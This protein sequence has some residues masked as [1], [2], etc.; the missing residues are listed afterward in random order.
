MGRAFLVL[1][2]LGAACRGKMGPEGQAGQP[3][4]P[5]DDGAP[6]DSGDAGPAGPPGHNGADAGAGPNGNL[7]VTWECEWCV[8]SDKPSCTLDGSALQVCVDDGGGCGHWERVE[9]C[10]FGCGYNPG[11]QFD[12]LGNPQADRNECRSEAS[13]ASCWNDVVCPPGTECRDDLG[14]CDEALTWVAA[15]ATLTTAFDGK[16]H[17]FDS[18][19]ELANV[20]CS[21]STASYWDQS[22]TRNCS[23]S[24]EFVR[25]SASDQGE[26]YE[27]HPV[28]AGGF[29][30]DEL[31]ETGSQEVRCSGDALSANKFSSRLS[32]CFLTVAAM[33]LT[34]GGFV[35]GNFVR[36]D[37]VTG[38]GDQTDQSSFSLAG[39]FRVQVP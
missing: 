37:A 21:G 15:S 38:P 20:D 23:L 28:S 26:A 11:D 7:N 30:V 16:V 3:G 12:D 34:P 31:T 4:L 39:T 24:L 14:T 5:G 27:G 8:A 33:D 10:E 2:V 29:E 6:G 36:T 35:V 17:H 32:T 19:F 18:L 9:D 1:C 25:W 13:T 22:S